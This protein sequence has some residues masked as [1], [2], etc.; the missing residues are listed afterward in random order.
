[1]IVFSLAILEACS[2]CP[3]LGAPPDREGWQESVGEVEAAFEESRECPQSPPE[4]VVMSWGCSYEPDVEVFDASLTYIAGTARAGLNEVFIWMEIV[5]DEVETSD[6]DGSIYDSLDERQ[7]MASRGASIYFVDDAT[8]LPHFFGPEVSEVKYLQD[9][10]KRG[11]SYSWV[12][13]E[14]AP[15][16]AGNAHYGG[17]TN[18][19]GSIFMH[20]DDL[21]GKPLDAFIAFDEIDCAWAGEDEGAGGDEWGSWDENCDGIDNDFDGEIDDGAVDADGN[22]IKDCNE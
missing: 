11:L 10:S 15:G 20:S 8:M 2:P 22:G 6:C 1:M 12:C 14:S 5:E 18:W 21:D 3:T 16:P 9:G 19:R 7:V 4:E 17:P 13:L